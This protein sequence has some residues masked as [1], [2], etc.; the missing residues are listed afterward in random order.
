V[1]GAVNA[2]WRAGRPA[3]LQ[4]ADAAS[5][6]PRR[7]GAYGVRQ[8]SGALAAEGREDASPPR[9]RKR[10]RPAALQDADATSEA[11]RR[12]GA[13]GV[14]QAPRAAIAQR[15]RLALWLGS[16]A[17]ANALQGST[18]GI[19]RVE[20]LKFVDGKSIDRFHHRG[21]CGAFKPRGG[22]PAV[23]IGHKR[24]TVLNRVL[25][26]VVQPSEIRLLVSEPGLTK[27]VPHLPAGRAVQLIDPFGS[28]YVKHPEHNGEAGCV[29]GCVG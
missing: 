23:L 26:G 17:T 12:G 3:A 27:V 2:L 18:D 11:P 6:A 1:V 15:R 8:A 10:Q 25:V 20:Y 21:R 24:E 14:R 29:L 13:C 9:E 16:D 4:D 7:G 5:E 19:V 22:T 28:S